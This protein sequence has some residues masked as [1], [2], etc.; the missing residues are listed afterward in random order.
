MRRLIHA[1]IIT[2]LVFLGLGV[3][4]LSGSAAPS[5]PSSSFDE[6][7][8][9]HGG[10]AALASVVAFR[11]EA[12]R[13]TPTIPPAF[14]ERRLLISVDGPRF[15]RDTVDPRGLR[16]QI[17]LIDGDV[18][19]YAVSD[20]S[21]GKRAE[22]SPV[23]PM[24]ADQRRGARWAVSISGL[25]HILQTC[26]DRA[27]E[28]SFQERTPAGLDKFRVK[29]PAG[30]W[31][32]SADQA[33]LIRQVE[34][35]DKIL[36]FAGYRSVNGLQLPFIERVSF[37]NRLMYELFFSTL[38]LNPGLPNDAFNPEAIAREIAG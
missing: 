6:V 31:L 16:H 36:Q 25:L 24:D 14:F 13:L 17:E 15:K 9:A 11:A 2:S 19:F 32:I 18:G 33:H 26:A 27:A 8:Q 30:D 7:L 28:I 20:R 12:L 10:R 37:G 22:V 29:T 23:Q 38:E 4:F 35:G 3:A 34:M 1:S 5:T 21:D